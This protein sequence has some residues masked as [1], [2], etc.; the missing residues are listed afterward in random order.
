M[1]ATQ[2]VTES[3][4]GLTQSEVVFLRQQQQAAAQRSHSGTAPERG[5]G[6]TR[7]SH[8]SASSR[9]ASAA[10]SQSVSGRILLDPNS[11]T[12]LGLHVDSILAS[13]S[14]RIDEVGVLSQNL[15]SCADHFLIIS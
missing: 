15:P 5:R 9:A 2:S 11:L 14:G 6:P 1:S 12:S 4:V 10:S 13:I 3:A 7:T 8:H